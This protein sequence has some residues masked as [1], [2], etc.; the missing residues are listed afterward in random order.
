[1]SK[2]K[3]FPVILAQIYSALGERDLAIAQLEKAYAERRDGLLWLKVDTG[4]D[5]LRSDPRFT[6]LM[7]RIGIPQ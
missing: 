6:D 7:H 2:Q 1:V 4:F 3:S 5:G